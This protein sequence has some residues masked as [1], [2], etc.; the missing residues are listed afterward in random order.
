MIWMVIRNGLIGLVIP[1]IVCC[2]FQLR[3]QVHFSPEFK[4]IYVQQQVR[5]GSGNFY[6]SVLCRKL[7]SLIASS[8]DI[9]VTDN[10]SQAIAIINIMSEDSGRRTIAVNN[11]DVKREYA[12]VYSAVYEVQLTSG[13]ILIAAESISANR[14]LLFDENQVL[15]FENAQESMIESMAEDLA[16]QIIRRLQDIK[17]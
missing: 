2:G 4:V 1:L 7:E 5:N 3:S 8:G 13:K 14:A 12:L 9:A 11:S 17:P 6:R 15:G 10:P 16:W